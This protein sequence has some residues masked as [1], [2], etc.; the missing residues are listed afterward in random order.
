MSELPTAQPLVRPEAMLRVPVGFASPLW[1]LFAGAAMTGSAW[2]WMTRFTR[3]ANLEA[4]FGT[5][6][7][8]AAETVP[9]P[10]VEAVADMTVETIEAMDTALA[11]VAEPVLDAAEVAVESSEAFVA[12]AE[13]AVESSEAFVAEAEPAVYLEPPAAALETVADAVTAAE[14]DVMEATVPVDAPAPEPVIAAAAAPLDAEIAADEP[15][16]K[17][18]RR[19][20][21]PKAD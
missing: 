15:V 16:A 18:R 9:A 17:P 10:V 20:P 14:V 1:G 7:S 21:A 6:E 11:Q 2:W 4:V 13:P 8:A 19:A 3:P 5:V 12:E